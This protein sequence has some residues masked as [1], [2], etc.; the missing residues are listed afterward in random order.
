MLA[1]ALIH[2]PN[3]YVNLGSLNHFTNASFFYGN[4]STATHRPPELYFKRDTNNYTNAS[5]FLWKRLL[6]TRISLCVPNFPEGFLLHTQG[7]AHFLIG[8]EKHTGKYQNSQGNSS[9]LSGKLTWHTE[10][11]LISPWVR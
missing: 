10:N 11:F 9:F 4:Y 3:S 1:Y 7:N 6:E 2:F 5:P 8:S